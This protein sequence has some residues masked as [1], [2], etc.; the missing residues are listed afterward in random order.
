MADL[1]DLA[2][3]VFA[4]NVPKARWI[5]VRAWREAGYGGTREWPATR[6]RRRPE[7]DKSPL[8]HRP[9]QTWDPAY[10]AEV[11]AHYEKCTVKT[12]PII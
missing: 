4:A 3:M 9:R 7:Y 12:T 5:T 2:C 10:V 11:Q 1:D 6:V 8:L